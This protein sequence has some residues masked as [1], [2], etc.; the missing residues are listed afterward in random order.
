[1]RQLTYAGAGKVEW[2]DVPAP[3]LQGDGEALVRPIAVTRCD[4]DF[5]IVTG[6]A[7]W[8]G[9]FA[10]GHET[11][12]VVT[13][14]G[15]A[16]RK[17]RP[18]DRVLVPF[19][20]SCGVCDT[21]RK[22]HTGN[23]TSVPYRSA[24]GMAPLSGVDFGGGISDLIRV[25]F[26]DAMLLACPD[27]IEP[28]AAAG[29]T[30]NV[31]DAFRSV[32]PYLAAMPKARVLI[33]GGLGQ[34]IG[35]YVAE[36]AQALGAA[37]TVYF[38]DDPVRLGLAR[39]L[40]VKV[41]ERKTFDGAAPGAPYSLTVDASGTAEG[42]GLA[43]RSTAHGG[44]CHRTYGDLKPMTEVSLREMYGIGMSLHLS[45][46]HARRVMPDV[47]EHVRCGHLHPEKIITRRVSFDDAADAIL[48]PHVKLVFLN[49][50]AES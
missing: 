23:C 42:L 17:F 48:E 13:D 22:G 45:R 46:V 39:S 32:A 21:C 38:D 30:D 50:G 47:V 14:V 27:E 24:Y 43:I 10:L 12:G 37:E 15:D 29:I 36:A 40:G 44:T 26:A 6:A 28:E 34:G 41:L 25:P 3:Q 2:R 49:E 33:V 1:M 31:S 5:S 18:G 9:P 8:P 19:Q 16:V 35:L 4:L 7:G 11:M 20:I